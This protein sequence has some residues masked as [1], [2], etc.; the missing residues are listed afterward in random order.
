MKIK[1]SDG[2][3]LSVEMEEFPQVKEQIESE[4]KYRVR[5]IFLRLN[6]MAPKTQYENSFTKG[7]N[8]CVEMVKKIVGLYIDIE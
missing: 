2:V 8:H 6:E 3:Y 1:L 7:Y 5:K 4:I